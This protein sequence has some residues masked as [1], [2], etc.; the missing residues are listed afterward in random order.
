MDYIQLFKMLANEHRLNI[1]LWLKKPVESFKIY[2]DTDVRLHA[3]Q[4]EFGVCVGLIQ[5]RTGLSQP[6][7]S[8]YLK[9]MEK[10]GL[11]VS[12][13]CGMW[14]HYARNEATLKQLAQ[15]ISQEL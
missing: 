5:Q 12:K 11:V 10:A 1:L 4:N 14:T 7:V 8:N 2:A 9:Q 13:R 15:F 6:T 3:L